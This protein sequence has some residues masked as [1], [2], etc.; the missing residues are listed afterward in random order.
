M[1]LC[2]LQECPLRADE[3]DGSGDLRRLLLPPCRAVRDPGEHPVP[4]LPGR[5]ARAPRS[6]AA[7]S[8][9][10]TATRTTARRRDRVAAAAD[11]GARR[12]AATAA[13]SRTSPP[14]TA[15]P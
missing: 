5:R 13:A 10:P 14:R 15:I 11:F 8:A 2:E 4:D 7:A 1:P 6:S 12:Q 3:E 9:R